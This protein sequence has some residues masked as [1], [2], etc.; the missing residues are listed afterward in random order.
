[1]LSAWLGQLIRRFHGGLKKV[2]KKIKKSMSATLFY[3]IV[4]ISIIK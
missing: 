1:M 3:L 2:Y 4:I